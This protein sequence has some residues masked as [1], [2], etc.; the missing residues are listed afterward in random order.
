MRLEG[1]EGLKGLASSYVPLGKCAELYTDFTCTFLYVNDTSN[2]KLKIH[3][4]L[5]AIPR[6][7]DLI[8][9]RHG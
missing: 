5:N 1:E 7:S 3:S 8:G 9:L 4:H 2:N 6:G